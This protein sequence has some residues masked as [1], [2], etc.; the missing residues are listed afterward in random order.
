MDQLRRRFPHT[1][2]IGFETPRPRSG[3]PAWPRRTRR[4]DREI[5]VAFMSEMRGEAPTAAETA[6][7]HTAVDA[8]CDDRDVDLLVR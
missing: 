7:L 3:R 8:C 6:L 1:L 4:S 5:A 2:V